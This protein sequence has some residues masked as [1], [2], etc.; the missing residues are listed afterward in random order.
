MAN[1][2]LK[3]DFLVKKKLAGNKARKKSFIPIKN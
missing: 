2:G 3:S 1:C